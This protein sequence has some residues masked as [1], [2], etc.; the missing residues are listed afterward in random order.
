M[1]VINNMA[2][3]KD[4]EK[5]PR[6]N[7]LTSFSFVQQ[8]DPALFPR[9]SDEELGAVDEAGKGRPEALLKVLTDKLAKAQMTIREA[10]IIVH[11]KDEREVWD[12]V[13]LQSVMQL[14]A[15]HCHFVAKAEDKFG[16]MQQIAN[17]LEV[18]VQYIEKT[19]KGRYAYDNLL[20]YLIHAKDIDKYQ[21]LPTDVFSVVN[22]G[23][24]SY[25]DY[26]N[27]RIADWIKARA[28]K[29]KK[30]ADEGIDDLEQKILNGEVTIQQICLSDELYP[31]YARYKRRCDDAFS[32]YGERRAWKTLQA[33]QDGEFKLGVFYIMGEP[34]AGKT[35]LAKR[36]VAALIEQ[37]EEWTED[38]W[39]VCQTAATNPMDEYRGEEILLM[40]DVRGSAMSASDWL[41]LMDPYNMSP[42]SA[43]YHNKMPACRVVIITSTKDP[44]EFFYYCK[45]MGGG[46]RSEALDQFMR[47]IQSLTRVIK[48]EDFSETRARIASA[49]TAAPYTVAIPD[50]NVSV[51][52]SYR[53]D[54]DGDDLTPDQAVEKLVGIVA[55]NQY[56]KHPNQTVA[57]DIE[58][59]DEV[60]PDEGVAS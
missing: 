29:I 3:G 21:Y 35:R 40:D 38:Q 15:V 9:W 19:R 1:G 12:E 41:K 60:D 32:V 36:F 22:Q 8:L 6:E 11:D 47:R 56:I 45:N 54:F 14:K 20:S 23:G 17:A 53:F 50:G 27:E 13:R 5:T 49:S 33:L 10:H 44:I 2:K 30:M 46:D 4:A 57:K 31:I 58:T 42:A 28:K 59:L 25:L 39:R 16:T 51:S 48:A 37:S 55:D 34:G 24:R 43:R 26:Y 52:L 18:P 7:A